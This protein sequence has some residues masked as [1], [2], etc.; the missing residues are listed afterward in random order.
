[1]TVVAAGV[2]DAVN[3]QRVHIGA[4]PDRPSPT[5]GAERSDDPGAG[6]AAMDF[7]SKSLERLRDPFGC[8]M[9]V[10]RQLGVRVN[11]LPPRFHIGMKIDNAFDEGHGRNRSLCRT[12]SIERYCTGRDAIRRLEFPDEMTLIRKPHGSRRDRR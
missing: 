2:H 10:E 6:Q 5:T 11:I 4:Q 9:L 7:H 8:T 12:S 3:G 1:M